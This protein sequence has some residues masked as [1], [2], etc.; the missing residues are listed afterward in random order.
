MD[1]Y[2]RRECIS[3]GHKPGNVNTGGEILTPS[4]SEGL[5]PL[6]LLKFF[7]DVWVPEGYV[8]LIRTKLLKEVV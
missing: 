8:V 3:E 7:P 1:A 5:V 6:S 2:V 4:E